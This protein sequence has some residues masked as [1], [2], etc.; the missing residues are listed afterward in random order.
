MSVTGPLYWGP[1]IMDL[2]PLQYFV[3][4]PNN[5]FSLHVDRGT[6]NDYEG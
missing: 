5:D 1:T 4:P 3:P 2:T 6:D